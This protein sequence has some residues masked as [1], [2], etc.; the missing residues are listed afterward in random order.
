MHRQRIDLVKAHCCG[1]QSIRDHFCVRDRDV[2]AA[3]YSAETKITS[4]ISGLSFVRRADLTAFSRS[5]PDGNKRTLNMHDLCWMR[6]VVS[7][8]QQGQI[9]SVR[10]DM[11]SA[12]LLVT[13]GASHVEVVGVQ[14]PDCSSGE[15]CCSQSSVPIVR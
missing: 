5:D 6:P 14:Q 8:R 13:D 2:G 1:E 10:H 9:P 11:T 12:E 15:A 4:H 3:P 7:A